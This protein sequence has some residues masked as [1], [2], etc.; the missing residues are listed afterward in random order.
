MINSGIIG[1][2]TSTGSHDYVIISDATNSVF[3]SAETF[4]AGFTD[5]TLTTRAPR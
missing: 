3:H 1:P 4:T 5:P 2:E